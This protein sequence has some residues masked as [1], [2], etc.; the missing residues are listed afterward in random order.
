MLKLWRGTHS[1]IHLVQRTDF[2]EEGTGETSEGVEC[3]TVDGDDNELDD[4]VDYVGQENILFGDVRSG[5][6]AGVVDAFG[7]F[8]W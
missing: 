3:Q 8:V 7:G 5:I 1:V 4:S 6:L 2:C